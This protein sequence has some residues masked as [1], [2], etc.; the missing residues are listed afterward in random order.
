[1]Y[2][3]K[4]LAMDAEFQGVIGVVVNAPTSNEVLN[5]ERERIDIPLA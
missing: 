2:Q 1:M 4:N 5:K 3:D